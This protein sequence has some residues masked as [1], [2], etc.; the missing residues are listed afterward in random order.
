M[1]E[2]PAP[3]HLRVFVQEMVEV[4]VQLSAMLDHMHRFQALNPDSPG[5][6][7]PEVLR[8][9]VAKTLQRTFR[10][11]KRDVQRATGLLRLTSRTIADDLVLVD[12][13]ALRDWEED[14]DPLD[15]DL[16]DCAFD[17]D[18]D[19]L[20]LDPGMNVEPPDPYGSGP[21]PNG[22]KLY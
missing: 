2:P 15:D 13:R 7:P 4:S 19:L 17:P 11:S 14:D 22:H 8:D 5:T 16:C 10:A 21:D 6:P 1:N 20:E 18:E 9:L 3:Q 12:P